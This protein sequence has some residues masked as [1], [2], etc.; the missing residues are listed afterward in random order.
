MKFIWIGED[1]GLTIVGGQSVF[2][3]LLNHHPQIHILSDASR[4][5][6]ISSPSHAGYEIYNLPLIAVHGNLKEKMDACLCLWD[7]PLLIITSKFLFDALF[8]EIIPM[9][10][11]FDGS[12]PDSFCLS[13][14]AGA[15]VVFGLSKKD[16]DLLKNVQRESLGIPDLLW[17]EFLSNLPPIDVP[18]NIEAWKWSLCSTEEE[19][20]AFCDFI[21][22]QARRVKE[23]ADPL[24]PI[25]TKSFARVGLVGN[26]SDG[27]YG[28][29][30]SF[31]ISNFYAQ[32]C[33]TPNPLSSD[34]SVRLE[35]NQLTDPR[36]FRSMDQCYALLKKDGYYGVSRLF[37]AT[38]KVFCDYCHTHNLH[39]H[40]RGFSLKYQTNIPRQVGLSGSSAFVTAILKALVIFYN[41]QIPLH[42][43]ANLALSA[44]RDEL[45]I[46]AG[47]Q[48]R[49]IQIYGG[50]VFMDFDRKCMMER[51]Y[52]EYSRIPV[53]LLPPGLWI[54]IF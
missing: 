27:F 16:V 52:G 49:V 50:C 30:I 47:H 12:I 4:Y 38:V 26:P 19:I 28:R 29:T 5:S 54:G 32:V 39:Q 24:P 45:G 37:L 33:L 14:S 21:P 42:I 3:R 9:A 20:K 34:T 36:A 11:A 13:S 43:Q 48:D 51:G 17:S 18:D 46:S 22:S 40:K 15:P 25:V 8:L 10:T 1:R 44:E 6:Y 31:L 23:I 7:E 41:V 53:S 2:Q 35:L